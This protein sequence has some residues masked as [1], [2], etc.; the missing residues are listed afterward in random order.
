MTKI[1]L[2]A[3]IHGNL[4]ALQAVLADLERWSPDLVVVAGDIVNR[5]P[6]SL[7]CL[8]LV[9]EFG[10]TRDWQILRG[11]HERYMLQYE[12]DRFEPEFLP[13][14]PRREL[15]RPIAWTH[16]SLVP[17]LPVIAALPEKLQ[18][19]LDDE[20]VAIYHASVRH[21]R[22]GVTS[23]SADAL[24]REQIDP[25]A[26]L[27]GIGHTHV[28]FVRRLDGT[29]VVNAGSVGL[30]FDGDTRA[31][32]A[33]IRRRSAEWSAEI[34]R[35][36]YDLPA[37]LRD[38]EASGMLEAVGAQA[39]LMLRELETGRSL[40]YGFVY[41]YYERILSGAITIDEAVQQYLNSR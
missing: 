33:R 5:G 28:P 11:N 26:T 38:V 34:V 37:A 22:D 30:P 14:G 36:P 16:T 20:P 6:R 4:V 19:N 18:F 17:H 25:A 3:D 32:Y 8:E 24:L 12:R 29:L 2:L 27:F 39:P 9:L 21:D 40:I 23:D 35:V 10:A 41:A 15:I 1:A 13:V 7:E 31:A